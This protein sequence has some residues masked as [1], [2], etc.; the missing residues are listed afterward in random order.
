MAGKIILSVLAV[1]GLASMLMTAPGQAQGLFPQ[2]AMGTGFTYQGRLTDGGAAAEGPF[3]CQFKLYDDLNAGAQ[4]GDTVTREDVPVSG[5]LF[6]VQLDF[7]AV[8]DGAALYL[9]IGVRPGS[10][11]GAYTTLTPRQALTAAP[12]AAYALRAPW[13]GLTGVPAGFPDGVDDNTTYTAGSGLSLTGTEF[14]VTG[15]PWSGL[16]GVPA[17]FADGVDNNTAYTAG[18]GLVLTDT[19]FSADTTYVQRRVSSDCAEGS[20][21]RA[22]AE[23]GT[24]TCETDDGAAYTA[25]SG[26]VL[27]DTTFSAD[28]TYV[29]RRVSSDCAEGSSIRAIA[30]D[31][32]VTCET[33]DNTTYTAG[34]G[35]SLTDTTFSA[36]TTYVQRRVSSTC[37]AGSSIRAIAEDGTVTCET[38]DN[39]TYSAGTGLS[40]SGTTFSANTTY[41]QRRV[42]STCT[43]GSSISAIAADGTVTCETDD[44]TTYTA[45]T[46]LSLSGT[47]FSADTSYLQ[48]RV[49]GSC[50]VGSSVRAI[51]A[52]GTVTCWSDAPLN[53]TATPTGNIITTVDSAGDVGKYSS[54]TI[55]ANGLP[56][57]SY[58]DF[59]NNRVKR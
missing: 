29:Q 35:L 34:A 58:M 26:L 33:D 23:D 22:I 30:A 36:D 1:W 41:L 49:S 59:T 57:I 11:S 9:E 17:G 45:G 48:R 51:N 10:S 14:A 53:R 47:T 6:T 20:S 16:T 21:I 38:D 39:T 3:D 2:A 43:T 32:T 55:G 40:L 46:G 56:I 44:N 18:S 27:T 13:A 7:G 50:V 12:Y 52:D 42:S 15:A 4:V 54:I 19:T 24:V 8:F 31:G 28:T 37:T 5:G 25:G